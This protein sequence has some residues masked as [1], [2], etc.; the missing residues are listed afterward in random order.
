MKMALLN[1]ARS[2]I[3]GGEVEM[4]EEKIKKMLEKQLQLLSQ[5]S[6][7]ADDS[8]LVEISRAMVEIAKLLL[9]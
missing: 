8:N 5:H 1:C 2:Q 3:K 9:Y 4:S 6:K 7:V